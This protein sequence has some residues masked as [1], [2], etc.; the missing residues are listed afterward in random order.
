M[1]ENGY[2]DRAHV[3]MME[4]GDAVHAAYKMPMWHPRVVFAAT[5]RVV[6]AATP[7]V[8]FAATPQLHVCAE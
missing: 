8:V 3:R 4:F 7:R 6:L 1:Q 2:V 5:P